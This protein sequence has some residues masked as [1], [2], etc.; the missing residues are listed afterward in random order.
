MGV[1]IRQDTSVAPAGAVN[2][3]LVRNTAFALSTREEEENRNGRS[4][5]GCV[6][7]GISWLNQVREE[8]NI[9]GVYSLSSSSFTRVEQ[10]G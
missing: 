1:T 2:V 3:H 6:Q 5:S 10:H 9:F 8:V 4:G 7:S